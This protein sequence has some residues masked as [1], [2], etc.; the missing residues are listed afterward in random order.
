MSELRDQ[1]APHW[2]GI[3][4]GGLAT[5]MARVVKQL[6]Q[7]VIFIFGARVLGPE[8]FGVFALV[9]VFAIMAAQIVQAG[10]SGFILS[11][12]GADADLRQVLTIALVLSS[13]ALCA[14]LLILVAGVRSHMSDYIIDIALLFVVWVALATYADAQAALL[15]RDGKLFAMAMCEM[16]TE[17]FGMVVA[18]WLLHSGLGALALVWGRIAAQGL[19]LMLCQAITKRFP[20]FA[21]TRALIRDWARFSL[22]VLSTRLLVQVR[23]SLTTV[24]IG[25]LLGASAVGLFRGAQRL[26]GAVFE[27]VTEPLRAIAWV[28]LRQTTVSHADPGSPAAQADFQRAM[29]WLVPVLATLAAPVF[30]GLSIMS[31]EIVAIVLGEAWREAAPLLTILAIAAVPNPVG[32]LGA[33][34]GTDGTHQVF[35]GG[36]LV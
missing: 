4:S 35:P 10:T 11:L 2:G 1:A 32:L 21:M 13:V 3:V 16:A 8:D 20:T 29:E 7:I 30:L 31:G 18:L 22:H 5:A 23:Q 14:G 15:M 34:L 33:A 6:A 24:L 36:V 26:T 25:S 12:K 19:Q 9:S 27:L 17:I 28:L